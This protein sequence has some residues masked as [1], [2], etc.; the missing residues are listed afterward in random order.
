MFGWLG[1]YQNPSK[2][3]HLNHL[4]KKALCVSELRWPSLSC[5]E[6]L[7][8]FVKLIVNHLKEFFYNGL[9][10]MFVQ[11]YPNDTSAIIFQMKLNKE[12][13][14]IMQLYIHYAETTWWDHCAET[15]RKL[16]FKHRYANLHTILSR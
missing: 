4:L 6:Y 16:G 8:F 2:K 10:H 7:I 13:V 9:H 15:M 5:Q 14:L 11:F 3:G 1:P 12:N